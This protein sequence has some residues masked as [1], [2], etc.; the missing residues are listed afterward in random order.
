MKSKK[1]I[2]LLETLLAVSLIAVVG[3]A[4]FQVYAQGT[5]VWR[6]VQT[7]GQQKERVLIFL[8][9]FSK[10]LKNTFRSDGIPFSGT[11]QSISLAGLVPELVVQGEEQDYIFKPGRLQYE[12]DPVQKVLK[13]AQITYPNLDKPTDSFFRPEL[14]NIEEFSFS[15][16]GPAGSGFEPEL[17]KAANELPAAVGV[18]IKWLKSENE[19]ESV[20]KII[21]LPV[22]F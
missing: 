20:E 18:K 12:F 2:T 3:L 21:N 8:E 1:G 9:R 11:A 16:Y 4:I 10:E 13:R 22:N 7:T 5:Q 15:Y 14:E 6:R 17:L 19:V